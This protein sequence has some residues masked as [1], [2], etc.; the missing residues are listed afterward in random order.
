MNLEEAE[1]GVEEICMHAQVLSHVQLFV[2]PWTIA[3]QALLSMGLPWQEYWSGLLF[4]LLEIF[5]TQG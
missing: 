4:P 5:L 1:V 2:N 3:Y